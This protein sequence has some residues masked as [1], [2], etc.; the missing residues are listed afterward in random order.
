MTTWPPIQ[1]SIQVTAFFVYVLY[2]NDLILLALIEIL[3]FH[4]INKSPQNGNGREVTQKDNAA[5]DNNHHYG[6]NNN[7]C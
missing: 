6:L 5:H 2:E 1:N 3:K 4:V 7:S